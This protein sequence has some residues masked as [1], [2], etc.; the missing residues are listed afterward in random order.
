[1]SDM[2]R[3][4]TA[5]HELGRISV[6]GSV[7]LGARLTCAEATALVEVLAAAGLPGI[8]ALV[9][10]HHVAACTRGCQVTWNR[11]A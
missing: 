2:K 7:S 1:M 11:G 6:T 10:T 3:L 9:D 8:A 4:H 5:L